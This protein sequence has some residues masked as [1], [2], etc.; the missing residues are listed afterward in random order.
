MRCTACQDALGV[1]P[2]LVAQTHDR[3]VARALAL[4]DQA[5]ADPPHQRMEPEQRFD[6]HV[7]R[8]GEVVA[9]PHVR[10]LVREHRGELLF[11]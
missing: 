5:R 3:F 7:D 8:R 6:R 1:H 9:P 2:R 11:V 10:E 4:V